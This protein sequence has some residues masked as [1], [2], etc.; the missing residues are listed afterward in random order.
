MNADALATLQS[1][2]AA[3]WLVPLCAAATA[4]SRFL[5]AAAFFWS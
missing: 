4:A 5:F 1:R 3:Y 2:Q